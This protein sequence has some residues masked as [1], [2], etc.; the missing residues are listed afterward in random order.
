MAFNNGSSSS[1]NISYIDNNVWSTNNDDQKESDLFLK[2]LL[3]SPLTAHYL[4]DAPVIDDYELPAVK[5]E[6][7]GMCDWEKNLITI[8]V[9]DPQPKPADFDSSEEEEVSLRE[10]EV[11]EE[12]EA[13]D[14]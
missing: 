10:Q 14:E 13:D 7:A 12:D 8:Y 4:Q 3:E 2:M 6:V 1:D 5:P 9:D 11:E